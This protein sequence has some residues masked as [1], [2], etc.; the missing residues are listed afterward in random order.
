MLA[1]MSSDEYGFLCAQEDDKVMA[2]KMTLL[3]DKVEV[4]RQVEAKAKDSMKWFAEEE[5]WKQICRVG[6]MV[7]LPDNKY[8]NNQ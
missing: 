7:C 8:C 4:Y 2:D 1:I 5:V 6:S 3:M